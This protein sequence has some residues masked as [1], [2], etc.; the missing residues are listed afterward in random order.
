MMMA[1]TM[2]STVVAVPAADDDNAN[3]ANNNA[4]ADDEE[5]GAEGADGEPTAEPTAANRAA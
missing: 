5:K 4:D 2:E 3:N 1:N